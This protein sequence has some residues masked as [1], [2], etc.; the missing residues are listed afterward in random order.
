MP[1]VEQPLII[2]DGEH[3]TFRLRVTNESDG[4]RVNLGG[5]TLELEVKHADGASDPALIHLEIGSGI[6]LEPQVGDT[7]GEALIDLAPSDLA[8]LQAGGSRILR[9]DVTT[10]LASGKRKKVIPPSDFD[11]RVVVNQA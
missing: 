1:C 9:Y 11:F 7:E 4:S 5:A 8:P 2:W 6:T 3:R 10:L